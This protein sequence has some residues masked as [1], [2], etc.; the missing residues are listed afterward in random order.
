[1][2]RTLSVPAKLRLAVLATA[3][4]AEPYTHLPGAGRQPQDAQLGRQQV[5]HLHL[6]GRQGAADDVGRDRLGRAADGG[7]VLTLEGERAGSELSFTL[8]ELRE[9][10]LVPVI[11]FK[12]RG[13]AARPAG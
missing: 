11:D 6:P 10:R 9:A 1:M 5:R 13:R 3:A 8:D 4:T 2:V 12:G 7:Y